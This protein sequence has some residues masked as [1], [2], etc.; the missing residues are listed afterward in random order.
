MVRHYFISYIVSKVGGPTIG[1]AII[2]VSKS[3]LTQICEKIKKSNGF[4]KMPIITFIRELDDE[5]FNM[6]NGE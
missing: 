4:E 6:L 5:E 2:T 1:Q 3:S